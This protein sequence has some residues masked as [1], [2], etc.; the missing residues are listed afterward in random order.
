MSLF[1]EMSSDEL[2]RQYTLTCLLEPDVCSEKVTVYGNEMKAKIEMQRHL[3]QH[4]ASLV[5]KYKGILGNLI[6][7]P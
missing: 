2:R 4:L 5:L 1:S 6:I 7:S 3:T